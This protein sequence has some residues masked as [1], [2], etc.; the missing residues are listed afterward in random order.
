MT[1]VFR[2]YEIGHMH[3]V[4]TECGKVDLIEQI[5]QFLHI[6]NM[7]LAVLDVDEFF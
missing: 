3:W 4:V 5:L 7:D 1:Q 2:S 6:G